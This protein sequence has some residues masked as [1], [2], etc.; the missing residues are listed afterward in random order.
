MC[1]GP[2]TLA[3]ECGSNYKRA[4][5]ECCP[6]LACRGKRCV[7]PLLAQ[8]KTCAGMHAVAKECGSNW[9]KAAPECCPGLTCLGTRCADPARRTTQKEGR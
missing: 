1:A 7:D 3:I 9:K 6:G 8:H 2:H 4:A 5:P